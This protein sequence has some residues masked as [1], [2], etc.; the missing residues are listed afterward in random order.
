M[1]HVAVG[2]EVVEELIGAQPVE[3]ER[4]CRDGEVRGEARCEH[5]LEGVVEVAPIFASVVRRAE[6]RR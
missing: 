4:L 5:L 3:V 2:D 6:E 1:E